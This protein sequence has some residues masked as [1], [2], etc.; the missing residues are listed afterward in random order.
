[1]IVQVFAVRDVKA[2]TFGQPFF[3]LQRG[4]AIRSFADECANKESPWCKHPEDFA[5]FHLGA[6]DDQAGSLI[7]LEQPEKI[8]HAMDYQTQH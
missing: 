8:A 2:E 5:L 1:M 7:S 3:S 4:M 6:Y